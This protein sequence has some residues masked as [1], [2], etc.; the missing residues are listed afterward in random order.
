MGSWINLPVNLK[1]NSPS[2]IARLGLTSSF[3]LLTNSSDNSPICFTIF[4]PRIFLSLSNW[5]KK[6]I[7]YRSK[8]VFLQFASWKRNHNKYLLQKL[9]IQN[10]RLVKL[11]DESIIWCKF[12]PTS[13]VHFSFNLS[14]FGGIPFGS[15]FQQKILAWFRHSIFIA[16]K[17]SVNNNC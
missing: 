4:F 7:S 9:Q 10:S 17:H 6:Q 8:T 1:T 16:L 12:W 13:S 14:I 11:S 3:R 15:L 5:K 2:M